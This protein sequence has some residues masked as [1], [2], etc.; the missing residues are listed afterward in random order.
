MITHTAELPTFAAPAAGNSRFTR[1]RLF[2]IGAVV[3]IA[4]LVTIRR[5]HP[6]ETTPARADATGVIASLGRRAS[7]N[8]RYHAE[9][10]ATTPLGTGVRQRWTVQLTRRGHRRV[11]GARLAAR[12]WSPETGEV[13]AVAPRA[14][15][16]GGGR[17]RVD[18]VYFPHPGWWNIALVVQ[19]ATGTDSVAFNVV[20]PTST[21][22]PGTSDTA[23]L[24]ARRSAVKTR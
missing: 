17:Y 9:V 11:S 3:L 18:D 22:R 12:V 5:T 19:A 16:V 6:L 13:S 21:S 2:L 23:S 10:V 15:Y 7:H 20:L 8:Q 24:D 14:E 4:T 1:P